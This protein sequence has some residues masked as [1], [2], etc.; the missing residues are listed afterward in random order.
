VAFS[1]G[2]EK[3]AGLGTLFVKGTGKALSA[4]LSG[5]GRVLGGSPGAMG[6]LGVAGVA[7]NAKSKFKENKALMENAIQR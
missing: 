4:G 7:A 2:F 5:S 6:L 3:V 1:Q